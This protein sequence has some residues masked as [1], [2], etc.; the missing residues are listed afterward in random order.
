MNSARGGYFS[1]PVGS[2]VPVPLSVPGTLSVP[3]VPADEPVEAEP[4]VGMFSPCFF[5]AG[6]DPLAPDD[7]EPESFLSAGPAGSAAMPAVVIRAQAA[8]AASKVFIF[9]LQSTDP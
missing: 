9:F 4:P 1:T 7:R 3:V 6:I 5:V 8:I 2:D